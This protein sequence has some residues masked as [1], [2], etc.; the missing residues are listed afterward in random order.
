MT[1]SRRVL[2]TRTAVVVIFLA[3]LEI[4]PRAG[5]V[6]V[7]TLIPLPEMTAQLWEM[8][9]DGTIWPHLIATGSMVAASF[10]LAV[11]TGLALGYL[12]WRRKLLYQFVSPYLVTY[13]ALP[14]FAFYPVLI[15]IFGVNPI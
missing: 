5:W 3:F 7:L 4:A 11:V 15:G 8:F 9:T 13:Y 6:V 12:L 2:A 1:K 10:L 14:I